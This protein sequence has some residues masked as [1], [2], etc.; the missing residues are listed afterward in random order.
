MSV[1]GTFRDLDD[2]DRF[3]WIRGFPSMAERRRSLEAFYGGPVWKAN[4]QQANGTMVD[5]DNVLLLHPARQGLELPARDA[6]PPVGAAA[7]DRGIVEVGLLLLDAPADD[8]TIDLVASC[9][10]GSLL[11]CLVTEESENDFPA[12]PVREGEHA[13]VWLVGHRNG[14]SAE[15]G[16]QIDAVTSRVPHVRGFEALRLA[17]TARS[18]LAGTQEE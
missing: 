6:R 4:R 10:Q 11:C 9:L 17:P 8:A 1:I 15:A 13:L 12:L 2:D 16:A 3:V 18:L 14:A 5:S 7:A